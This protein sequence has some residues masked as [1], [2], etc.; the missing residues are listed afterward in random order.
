MKLDFGK[1]KTYS[2]TKRLSKVHKDDFASTCGKG[3][4]FKQFYNSLPNILA[5]KEIKKISDDIIGAR[6]KNKTILFMIGAHVIKCGLSPLIISLMKKKAITAVALNGA[7]I[8]HDTELAFVGSTSEDVGAA[9]K[10]GSFG[11]AKETAYFIND[12]IDKGVR[13]GMGIGKS[14]GEKILKERLPLADI[15]IL[16]N[17]VKYG[18]PV[19]VHV[20]IGTDIIH[21][22]PSCNGAAIGEGSLI[23]FR[24]LIYSVIKLNRGGVVANFGSA[25]IL[26]EVFLKALNTARNLGHPVKNF[27]AAN[28]D[29]ITHYR[30]TENVVKRPTAND[31]WGYNIIGHHEIMV[32]LLYQMVIE[33]L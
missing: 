27:T 4:S 30:P 26:P 15:S 31:G 11:M 32:P 9:L 16:A 12:A 21:Q 7:G 19:T 14:V 1:I 24:N 25:V 2:I 18:I 5:A 29:M 8:I 28:F 33:K 22:H 23:D 17:S 6:K 10:D 13:A 3:A 20:A